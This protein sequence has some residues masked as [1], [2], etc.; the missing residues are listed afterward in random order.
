[1]KAAAEAT[2]S[3]HMSLPVHG[4]K[5]S[6]AVDSLVTTTLSV[7]FLAE[8]LRTS[9]GLGELNQERRRQT[10]S[11]ALSSSA[12]P[13]G[14][15]FVHRPGVEPVAIGWDADETARK[16]SER[17]S[18]GCLTMSPVDALLIAQHQ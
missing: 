13:L 11:A 1:M 17:Q 9:Q 14:S 15:L 18:W 6:E 16:E 8:A 2:V 7:E 10:V 5:H 12:T 3:G 4:Y